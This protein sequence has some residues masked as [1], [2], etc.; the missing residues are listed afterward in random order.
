MD[1]EDPIGTLKKVFAERYPYATLK[2]VRRNGKLYFYTTG[3]YKVD[4][5][6]LISI[7]FP[8]IVMIRS[9]YATLKYT[10]RNDE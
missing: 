4:S 8:N 6:R 2:V 10:Y 5:G 1:F 3:A 9:D 7:F